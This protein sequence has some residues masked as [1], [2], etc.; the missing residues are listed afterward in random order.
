MKKFVSI[1]LMSSLL[2][3]VLSLC[4]CQATT[5]PFVAREAPKGSSPTHEKPT[6]EEPPEEKV[7]MTHHSININGMTLNYT[8]FAGYLPMKDEMGK[9]KANIFFTSYT[10]DGEVDKS[11]R[12]I[13]FA[14]NGGPGAASVFLHLGALGPKRI[15]LTEKGEALPPPYKLVDNAYT[16]LDFTDLVFIDPVGTGYSRAAPGEDPKQFWGVKEDIQSVGEF[17]RLYLTKYNRWLSPKFIAGESYGT[18]RAAG[19]SSHLQNK[20]SINLNGIVLISEALNFQAIV[21]APG[22]DLPYILFLPTYTST[23]WYHKK[24]LPELQSNLQKT[25]EEAEQ[26]TLNEYVLALAQGDLLSEA[27]R[28]KIVEKLAHYTGLQKHYIQNSNL[29]IRQDSFMKELLRNEHR[30]IGILD[31][32]ITGSYTPHDF[33]EDPSVFEVTDPMVATWNDYVRNELKYEND[34]PY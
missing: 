20:L 18:T 2:I 16:W 31:S 22:N 24:L 33:V 4:G 34:L 5:N 10:K 27:E 1:P 13:T 19:L 11:Q 26:F 32:R 30:R 29:R 23:A 17:I 6:V 8:A 21:F 15:L 12:P 3:F 9:L 25:L 7:S 14:F 28:D